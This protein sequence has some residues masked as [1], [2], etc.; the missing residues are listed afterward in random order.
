MQN[1]GRFSA[2]YVGRKESDTIAVIV[3]VANAEQ[4]FTIPTGASVAIFSCTGNFYALSNGQTAAVPG[5]TNVAFPSPN[6]NPELNPAVWDV[7]AGNVLS[8]IAPANC[9]LTV[10]FYRNYNP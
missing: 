6:T 4:H 10:A 8:V 7:T 5:A 2:P 3:L 9:T 1:I